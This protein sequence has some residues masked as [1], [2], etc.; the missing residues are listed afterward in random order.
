MQIFLVHHA[1]ALDP[2]IDPQRPLSPVGRAQ[3]DWLAA[4]ARSKHA[5]PAAIWHSGKLRARQTGEAFLRTCS[6]FAT[7]RMVRG[8][9]PG[10][11]TMWME[12]ALAMEERD[13]MVVGHMPHLA[14]L[15]ER[16]AGVAAFPLNG[17]VAIERDDAGAYVERWRARPSADSA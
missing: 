8:L 2:G 7:F 6:P 15:A 4:H 14:T 9:Q 11:P 13:V 16:L 17:M 12:D 3:A 10:D 5:A 1:N